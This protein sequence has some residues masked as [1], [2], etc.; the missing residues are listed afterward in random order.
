MANP[1]TLAA[2]Q[3]DCT[4]ADPESNLAAVMARLREAAALGAT[5]VVFPECIITG[6]GFADKAAA[7]PVADS[8][9][10]RI[11]DALAKECAALGV[12]AAVGLLEREGDRLFNACCLVGPRGLIANF[13]KIHLPCLGIDRFVTPG[14]R[15]FAVHDVDGFRVGI[16]IC[17]DNSFPESVRIMTLLGA[18]IVLQPTNWVWKAIKNATLVARVR[19]FENHIYYCAVNRVGIESGHSY[20]GHSS[21]VNPAG[22][23]LAFAEHDRP[24]ILTASFD[25]SLAR[26]KKIVHIPG[27]YELDRVNWR[28]PEMYGRLGE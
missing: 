26:S 15:P 23:F 27:E 3:M 7:M 25:P 2:V 4:L 9:P 16:G 20:C 21:I 14:D 13:R 19:A 12:T 24:A 10:G 8:V 22:D 18:D 17:F 6:Y 1:L 5:F 28:R 11:T